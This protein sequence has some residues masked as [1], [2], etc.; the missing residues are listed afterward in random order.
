MHIKS[1]VGRE[2]Y[3]SRGWP[4]V[5]CDIVLED[6]Y[7]C[8]ASV[9]TGLSTSSYEAKQ[10][11]D[12]GDRLWGRGVSKSVEIIDTTIAKK[13]IGRKPHAIDMDLE[14]LAMDGTANKAHLGANTLLAVSMAVYR[15]HAYLEKT[16]LF[17]FIGHICGA[18]TVSVPFP[19][20]NLING[21][22]HADSGLRIQE[23]MVVPVGTSDFKKAYEVGVTIFHELGEVLKKHNKRIAFGDEGGY[24]CS[25]THDEEALDCLSEAL[26]QAQQKYGFYALIALDVAATTFYDHVSKRYV[27]HDKLLMAEE[28]VG[29]Y[30]KLADKYPICTIED[31]LAED[32]WQGWTYMKKRLGERVQ[33]F[34]DDIFATNPERIAKGIEQ[35]IAHGAIIKPNQIGT[36]TEALQA[37]SLCQK[38]NFAT[39]VSHRSGDTE[40]SFIADLA[41]GV[42]AGHI[43]SGAPCRS[44]RCVKYNRLLAI[45]D[46]LIRTM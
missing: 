12:G 20:F 9:P 32:D 21:G 17:E 18:S 1:L 46:Y 33:L 44:E 6:G 43:K 13:F 15:A 39:F 45:E 25:F 3:D 30:E 28:M 36:V 41:V 2:I 40:D 27:W 11:H 38:N 23:F 16:E 24:S 34:G 14:L 8:S 42:S 35:K 26:E 10:L 37:V 31:G 29:I 5:Q 19:F 7:F 22:M 4:T